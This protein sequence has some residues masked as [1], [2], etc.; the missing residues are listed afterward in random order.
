MYS[1]STVTEKLFELGVP[2]AQFASEGWYLKT[3]DE[4]KDAAN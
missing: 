4:Q 3:L 2:T 1:F